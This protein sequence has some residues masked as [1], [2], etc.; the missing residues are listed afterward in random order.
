MNNKST[1]GTGATA[2]SRRPSINLPLGRLLSTPGAIEAMTRAGQDPLELIN[3]HGTGDWGEV[4]S[5]DW[6]ANDQ[7]VIHGERVLSAYT[8]KNAVRVW[9][10]TEAD[11]AATTILLP[12]EY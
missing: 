10:I 4:D 8:L 7:A 5:E 9:I 11:R 1:A 3:R 2:P 6:V 12:D